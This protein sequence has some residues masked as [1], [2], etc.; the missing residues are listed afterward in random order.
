MMDRST[1]ECGAGVCNATLTT[2]IT[3]IGVWIST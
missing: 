3:L 2:T 1:P